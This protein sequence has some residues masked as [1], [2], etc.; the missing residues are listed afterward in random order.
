MSNDPNRGICI[1]FPPTGNEGRP[2]HAPRGMPRG[3]CRADVY[4]STRPYRISI[5]VPSPAPHPP[6]RMSQE[7]WITRALRLSRPLWSAKRQWI[8]EAG[9]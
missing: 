7:T 1:K 4:L 3:S 2:V 6:K 9:K 5:P 8:Y